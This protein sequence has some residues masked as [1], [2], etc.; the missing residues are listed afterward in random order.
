LETVTTVTIN[1]TSIQAEAIAAF[2][3]TCF[4]QGSKFTEV[5]SDP[6]AFAD[7]PAQDIVDTGQLR[8]SQQLDFVGATV[9]IFSWNVD[10]AYHVWAGYTLRN[11]KEQPGRDWIKLG[12][13]KLDFQQTFELLLKSKLSV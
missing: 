5:I 3:E 11:G 2:K 9:A 6:N 4:L 8:A 7:F 1:T 13:S 10:Y 12:F